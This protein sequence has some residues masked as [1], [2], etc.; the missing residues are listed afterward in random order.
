MIPKD[1]MGKISNSGL[2]LVLGT[3]IISY[4]RSFRKSNTSL[5]LPE[6][7]HGIG[8]KAVLEWGAGHY[9]LKTL[10][11]YSLNLQQ[12]RLQTYLC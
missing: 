2:L 12:Q 6:I 5:V 1:S 9:Q 3:S 7:M 8:K 11:D 10:V 4:E